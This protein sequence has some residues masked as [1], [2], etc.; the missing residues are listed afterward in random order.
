VKRS[1]R[2]T[3]R[4]RSTHCIRKPHIIAESREPSPRSRMAGGRSIVVMAPAGTLG[5]RSLRLT[6]RSA[7]RILGSP[8][9]HRGPLRLKLKQAQ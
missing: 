5:V 8:T 7:R 9:A 4:G 1:G 3:C 2:S 6:R